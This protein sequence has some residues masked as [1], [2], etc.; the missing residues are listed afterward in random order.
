ML[1][2]KMLRNAGGSIS[3]VNIPNTFRGS[4]LLA[5]SDWDKDHDSILSSFRQLEYC[6]TQNER[7]SKHGRYFTPFIQDLSAETKHSTSW[8]SGEGPMLISIPF[9][10]WTV[11]GTTPPLRF[12]IDPREGYQS[13]RT[14]SHLVRSILQHFY[15]LEDTSDREHHQVLNR[16]KPWATDRE[17]DLKVRRWYGHHP[18]GLNVDELWILVV[19][20]RHIVT[21]SS[22]QTWKSYWPPLQLPARIARISF[23]EIRNNFFRD[24]NRVSEYTAV[25]HVVACLSGAVGMLHRSFWMDM[26]LCLTDRYASYLSH[27][28]YRLLRAPSTKLVMDLLQVQEELNIVIQVTQ[29]QLDLIS[30]IQLALNDTGDATRGRLSVGSRR[31]SCASSSGLNPPSIHVEP[32]TGLRY[33]EHRSTNL[34]DPFTQLLAN[35]ER[36]YVDLCDLRDNSNNL[37]NRTIQLVNI[38]LEDHGK[39][40]LV[41]TIVTV[42]FL[43]LSFVATFFG[44][45][46]SDIRDMEHTQRLFWIVAATVTAGIVVLTTCLAF[47]GG[48]IYERFLMWKQNRRQAATSAPRHTS[49]TRE[50]ETF[51]VRDIKNL[52]PSYAKFDERRKDRQ[53]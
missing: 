25:N 16:H 36:E 22:N 45:N 35:L 41:F 24:S 18:T 14:S 15:R 11:N 17:L 8:T 49:F 19:D 1:R 4:C 20:S 12:Q 47:Y 51:I 32:D 46:V 30:Q 7:F 37:V 38:R 23:R 27:L 39:A 31:P 10:D 26:I 52:L 29:Q 21:F 34:T 33:G 50:T 42:V 9:L 2:L 13:S 44:M 48:S 5:L 3:Q 28:Q 43:P 40:I 53:G 6:I